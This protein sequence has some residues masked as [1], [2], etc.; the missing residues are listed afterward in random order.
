MDKVTFNVEGFL[1]TIKINRLA[2]SR[3]A[4]KLQRQPGNCRRQGRQKANWNCVF[5]AHTRTE[6]G[7]CT[8]I[9]QRG[10]EI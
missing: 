3:W 1:T 10:V 4:T 5:R 8:M 6:W 9:G 2:D 7:T